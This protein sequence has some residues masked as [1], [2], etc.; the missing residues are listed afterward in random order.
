MTP[1]NA[2]ASAKLPVLLD[3]L[4]R[5]ARRLA[6]QERLRHTGRLFCA[7]LVV[8]VLYLALGALR[9]P[10]PVRAALAPLFMIAASAAV[11]LFVWRWVYAPDLRS[12]ATE[13]DLR[14]DLKSCALARRMSRCSKH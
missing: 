14:G 8:L 6:L 13:A 10:Q 1:P 12:V 7:L 5:A 4:Q 9:V 11:M 2:S 3:W